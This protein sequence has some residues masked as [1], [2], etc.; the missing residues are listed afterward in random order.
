MRFCTVGTHAHPPKHT[1][2]FQKKGKAVKDGYTVSAV[3]TIISNL[4]RLRVCLIILV[5]YVGR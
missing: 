2:D 1:V 3:P 5:L 4:V